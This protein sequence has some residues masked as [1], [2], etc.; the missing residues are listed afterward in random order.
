MH[1]FKSCGEYYI[2]NRGKVLIVEAPEY[3]QYKH[4]DDGVL[5]NKKV[6]INNKVFVVKGIE[7]FPI[8]RSPEQFLH[9][10]VNRNIGILV[11]G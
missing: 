6:I 10:S 9:T 4:I 2:K 1:S 7:T 5:L 11:E 3:M 8:G